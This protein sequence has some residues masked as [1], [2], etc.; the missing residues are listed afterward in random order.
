MLD[1]AR[2]PS[3]QGRSS[4]GV[5]S[6]RELPASRRVSFDDDREFQ[7]GSSTS[8]LHQAGPSHSL[9][10]DGRTPSRQRDGEG[11][12]TLRGRKG[13]RFSFAS[14]FFEAM[15]DRVR[16]RSPMVERGGDVT[17]PRG[18]TRDRTY[19]DPGET[20]P[21]KERSALGRVAEAV[22]LE[23]EDGREHG[24]GWKEFRKGTSLACS[25]S[26]GFQSDVQQ[27]YTPIRSRSLSQRIPLLLCTS[28]MVRLHGSLRPSSTALGPSNRN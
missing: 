6:P 10:R 12:D 26:Q 1:L 14:A 22:G 24:D 17:P 8:H 23:V 27:A 20:T 28:T 7:V 5:W 19:L 15:K 21:L 25:L 9:G 11:E 4:S 2:S 13:K 16:S 18:R 3:R